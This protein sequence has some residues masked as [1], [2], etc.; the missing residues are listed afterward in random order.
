MGF[1]HKNSYK[2][3]FRIQFELVY[4]KKSFLSLQYTSIVSD[5]TVKTLNLESFPSQTG[6]K[7][8]SRSQESTRC[9]SCFSYS[10]W[11]VKEQKNSLGTTPC[12]KYGYQNHDVKRFELNSETKLIHFVNTD[13]V[14]NSNINFYIK[15][16]DSSVENLFN[17]F[18]NDFSILNLSF[19]RLGRVN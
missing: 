16:G 9:F 15:K 5:L 18:C 6:F 8:F 2:T 3:C 1:K 10:R 12:F 14:G 4:H 17:N 7:T 13:G 19:G 11:R